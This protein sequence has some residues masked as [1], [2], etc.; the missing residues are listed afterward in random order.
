MLQA[1][2]EAFS[3]ECHSSLRALALAGGMPFVLLVDL[4]DGS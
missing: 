4:L 1:W 2:T 3:S